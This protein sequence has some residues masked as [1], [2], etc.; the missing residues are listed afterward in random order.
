MAWASELAPGADAAQEVAA[1]AA[2]AFWMDWAFEAPAT[3]ALVRM[4][5][6]PSALAV[7]IAVE[8]ELPDE[9]VEVLVL[10]S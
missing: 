3:V 5:T 6:S 9:E 8:L 7:A 10:L 4:V 1:E 2:F